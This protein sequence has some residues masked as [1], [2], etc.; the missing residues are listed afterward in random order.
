LIAEWGL[1][2]SPA[3]ISG[4]D[5]TPDGIVNVADLLALIAAWGPCP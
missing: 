5:G 3:D 1:T 4:A 2:D